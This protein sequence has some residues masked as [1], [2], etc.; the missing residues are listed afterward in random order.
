MKPF[1]QKLTESNMVDR[2]T[3]THQETVDVCPHCHNEIGEKAIYSPD[4][5]KTFIHRPCEGVIEFPEKDTAEY[6]EWLR[7][8]IEKVREMRKRGL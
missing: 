1:I 3:K 4:Q 2:R 6:P 5:G 8:Q 7:P